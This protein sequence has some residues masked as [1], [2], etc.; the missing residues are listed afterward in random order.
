M[1]RRPPVTPIFRLL[2]AGLLLAVGLLLGGCAAPMAP[3][4]VDQPAV[5]PV[6]PAPPTPRP[7]ALEGVRQFRSS[8]EY[9]E[10]A[11]PVGISIP[12]IAVSS[13]LEELGRNP[14]GTIE[15]PHDWSRAGWYG[16]G[17]K[18]G[19][20]GPAVILG[21]VDSKHGPAVFY[22]L[23]ELGPGD[24]VAVQRGDGSTVKFV[25][26]RVERYDKGQFPTTAVYFPSL[27]PGLRLVTCGGSFDRS[28]A[29]YRDNIIVFASL[30]AQN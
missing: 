11:P 4:P 26:E 6:P 29:H 14:D 9:R 5:R 17:P 22:R 25:V 19:Q 21:H 7:S 8:R 28:T 24:E 13:S 1:A 3:G 15:V 2:T 12:A 23:R 30:A 18:P 20:S 10:V 16:E 27:E